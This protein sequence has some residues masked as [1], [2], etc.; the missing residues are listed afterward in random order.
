M[1]G[2]N[3][4]IEALHYSPARVT[5]HASAY[6][7]RKAQ[8]G[9]RFQNLRVIRHSGDELGARAR[10]AGL[11]CETR[12]SFPAVSLGAHRLRQH[13]GHRAARRD[14]RAGRRP[15]TMRTNHPGRGRQEEGRRRPA[16]VYGRIRVEEL[17]HQLRLDADDALGQ[18]DDHRRTGFHAVHRQG[19]VEEPAAS[20]DQRSPSIRPESS[21]NAV[22][23]SM[24]PARACDD[25][26]GIGRHL[27]VGIVNRRS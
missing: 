26:G 5:T 22:S 17:T 13:E 14:R 2:G 16:G 24:A 20:D 8:P 27:K 23:T 25:Q 18:L 4:V 1:A 12:A 11:Q 7:V 21:T 9:V 15:A 6:A 3:S 19:K 10:R